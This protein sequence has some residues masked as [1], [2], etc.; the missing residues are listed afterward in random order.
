MPYPKRW[1]IESSCR[2]ATGETVWQIIDASKGQPLTE[3]YQTA[4]GMQ[5]TAN[6]MKWD[7]KYR[8]IEISADG[9]KIPGGIWK[10]L[11]EAL[12]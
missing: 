3:L 5:Q 11:R 9:E 4:T 2:L 12:W 1:A 7:T 8:V 10:W 6:H